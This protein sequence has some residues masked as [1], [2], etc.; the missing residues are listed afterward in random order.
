VK[1]ICRVIIAA[2]CLVGAAAAQANEF[3]LRSVHLVIPAGPGGAF[4]TFAQ[5]L[6]KFLTKQ[7]P[8][9]PTIIPQYMSGAGG[10]R[11]SNYMA[12]TAPSDGS[13]LYLMH[14]SAVT[15]QLLYPDRVAYD[16]RKFIPLG[17]VSSLNSVLLVR[18]DAPATELAGF[19]LKQDILGSTGRGSYQ[20][21]VP[22]LMNKFQ[23]TKFTLI[24]GFAGTND[25][26]L[27][28]ERGE[29]H[30]MLASLLAI[31]T[32]RPDWAGG[33]GIA[34]IVF[35]MGDRADPAIPSIPLLTTLATSEKERAVY[36][37]LS[38]ERTLGRSLVA[39][40]G[41]PED[42]VK[43]LQSAVA[44]VLSDPEFQAS[45]IEQKIPL[46]SG[47]P[48]DLQATI[49]RAFATSQDVIATARQYMSD[50]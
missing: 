22:T 2:T 3:E 40:P 41:T 50:K 38:L 26:I 15:Y 31:Q 46:I 32:L 24:P 19:K 36:A 13:V 17:T 6:S 49:D 18:H 23:G 25:I 48:S 9:N 42:R 1:S 29:V 44:A 8:G 43:V 4:G 14:E 33:E 7:L 30:G 47:T 37:F 10:I 45:C 5:V 35:Q 20:F 21:V 28:L 27:A 39:P 34:K 16:A 11:A 12:N